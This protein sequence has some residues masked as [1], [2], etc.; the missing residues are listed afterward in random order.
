MIAPNAHYLL[1][2]STRILGVNRTVIES[3]EVTAGA[4]GKASD[5]A[6]TD[7]QAALNNR[8]TL[9]RG[10]WHFVLD[11]LD[12][13]EKLEVADSE[14]GLSPDRLALLC[15]VRGL[16][17]LE[18]PSRVTLVTTSRYVM[19]G[20]RFGLASWRESDYRWER[21]GVQKPIR[22]ADLWKRVDCALDY[23]GV[24][25]R[26][27]GGTES[28]AQLAE[29]QLAEESTQIVE[30]QPAIQPYDAQ[31]ESVAAMT[32][33]RPA[34][35]ASETKLAARGW[36]VQQEPAWKGAVENVNKWWK[37]RLSPKPAFAGS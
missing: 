3:D 24:D 26:M 5:T 17:A 28:A 27:L 18:Q 36:R 34:T 20:M 21:F 11:K 10:R 2:C 14:T 19:R 12:G 25:C 37:T 35:V 30:E 9:V 23:H 13:E 16:E 33:G 4:P 22:N 8:T 15:V 7:D 1:F 32:A 29:S 6:S 31:P